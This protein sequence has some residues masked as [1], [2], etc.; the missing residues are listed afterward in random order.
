MNKAAKSFV[1]FRGYVWNIGY[2]A[3]LG[4]YERRKLGIFNKGHFPSTIWLVAGAPALISACVLLANHYQRYEFARLLYFTLYPLVTTLS[5]AL[6][7]DAGI[8]FFFVLYGVLSVFF[9]QSIY[10]IVFSF[11]LS[12]ACYFLVAVI[13]KDYDYSLEKHNFYFYIFN[14]L[15]AVFFIFYG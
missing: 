1:R 9:L 6:R 15:L 4:S 13:W 14:H 5:Y 11:T 7:I 10:N 3:S 8:G 2:R 12:M